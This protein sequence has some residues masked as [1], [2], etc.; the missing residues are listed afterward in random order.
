MAEAADA[1]HHA[2]MR[3]ILHRDLKPANIL[4]DAKGHPHVTDF[5]LAKRVEARRR[6]DRSGRDPGHPGLHGPRAGR[7][8]TRC[9]HHGHRRLRPRGR[10]LRPVDRPG[11]LPG[12]SVVDTLARVKEQPPMPPRK[13]NAR[14]PRDLEVICLKCLEKDPRRRYTSAQALADDL[15][16][17]WRAARSCAA[18]GPVGKIREVGTAPPGHRG[19][20]SP[21]RPRISARLWRNTCT[22]ASSRGCPPSRRRD[23]TGRGRSTCQSHSPGDEPSRSGLLACYGARPGASGK[24]RNIAQVHAPSRICVPR[25]R[26]WEWDRLRYLCHLEERTIPAPGNHAFQNFLSWSPDGTRFVGLYPVEERPAGGWNSKYRSNAQ[27]I[28][29]RT[30]IGA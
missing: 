1:V 5:G 28:D 11:P 18:R 13:L 29:M 23:G 27:I 20:F 19:A 17:G 24:V 25:L 26:R 4:V 21:S 12:D 30:R 16:P 15:P 3:G 10:P 8:P 2:H 22:M 6:D 14:V 9:G 7:R